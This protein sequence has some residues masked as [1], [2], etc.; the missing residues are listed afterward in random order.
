MRAREQ[1]EKNERLFREVNERI[2]EIG[3]RLARHGDDDEPI[4][5]MCECGSTDCV[6]RL[7]LTLGEYD[8]VRSDP[9]WFV[10]ARG[11]ELPELE[12]VVERRPRHTIVE[13]PPAERD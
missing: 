12:R 4:S 11:H 6:V 7:D 10:V 1:V 9:T 2:R 8:H 5:F 13:K 3:G